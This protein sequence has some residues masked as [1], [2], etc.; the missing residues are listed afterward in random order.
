M[1]YINKHNMEIMT[2]I[3]IK[4][5]HNEIKYNVKWIIFQNVIIF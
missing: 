5:I 3:A 2:F 1:Q 4:S